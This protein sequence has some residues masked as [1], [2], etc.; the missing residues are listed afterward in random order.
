MAQKIIVTDKTTCQD[1]TFDS[2]TAMYKALGISPG[3][4]RKAIDTNSELKLDNGDILI[5][6]TEGVPYGQGGNKDN[7]SEGQIEQLKKRNSMI[8]VKIVELQNE[9]IVNNKKIEDLT[10]DL[11]DEAQ[12]DIQAKEY[13]NKIL[14]EIKMN[15][16]KN[17]EQNAA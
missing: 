12:A 16:T 7:S 17:A 10:I 1:R 3:R 4:I 2:K 13:R 15:R 14:A 8:E 6:R 9:L 5:L 11:E